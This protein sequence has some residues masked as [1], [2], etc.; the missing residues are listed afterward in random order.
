MK[1]LSA[2]VI[3]EFCISKMT[4]G[5]KNVL[6][7]IHGNGDGEVYFA[8]SKHLFDTSTLFPH[9]NIHQCTWTTPDRKTSVTLLTS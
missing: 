3:A 9:R 1:I 8:A 7:N 5:N 4:T 2:D 6:E